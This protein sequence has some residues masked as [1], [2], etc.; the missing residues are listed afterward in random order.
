MVLGCVSAIGFLKR[1]IN[2]AM[3]QVALDNFLFSNIE[4]KF[5]DRKRHLKDAANEG[6]DSYQQTIGHMEIRP[7]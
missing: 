7:D 2:A 1:S 6:M 5:G 4:N 3:L